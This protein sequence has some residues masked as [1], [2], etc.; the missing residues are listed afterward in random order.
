M[1]PFA[2]RGETVPDSGGCYVLVFDEPRF[3]GRREFIN[4]PAKYPT[5]TSLP[6]NWQGRIR[7]ARVGIGAQVHVWVDEHF[8]GSAMTLRTDDEY[9]A[10]ASMDRRIA[11]M[12]VECT[13]IDVSSAVPFRGSPRS[14]VSPI[15][16]SISLRSMDGRW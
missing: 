12:E 3:M 1:P 2:R 4:G 8:Q 14:R 15:R 7:S 13:G 5:L 9:P 11:S 16:Y 6:G 10:F